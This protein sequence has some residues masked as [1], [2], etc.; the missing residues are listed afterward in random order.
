MADGWGSPACSGGNSDFARRF[1]RLIR[2]LGLD[3]SKQ[4]LVLLRSSKELEGDAA[5]AD[6]M[7]HSGYF[8]WRF[9]VVKG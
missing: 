7:D 4:T 2:R 5:S 1:G 9:G 6:R 8:K 3:E